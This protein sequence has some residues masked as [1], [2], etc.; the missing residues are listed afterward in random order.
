M[1][2]L[3]NKIL[4]GFGTSV[5]TVLV[6]E[7]IASPRRKK[8]KKAREVEKIE[9]TFKHIDFIKLIKNLIILVYG[10]QNYDS[11]L[12]LSVGELEN[13]VQKSVEKLNN[14]LY[15]ELK[16][17]DYSTR[18]IEIEEF[19][20]NLN[21]KKNSYNQNSIRGL[22]DD[23]CEFFPKMNEIF[24]DK[25][26]ALINYNRTNLPREFLRHDLT[27]NEIFAILDG[28][29]YQEAFDLVINT[30]SEQVNLLLIEIQKSIQ[31]YKSK[32]ENKTKFQ[33]IKE[34]ALNYWNK[35][36]ALIKLKKEQLT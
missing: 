9:E 3:F 31:I 25:F 23:I 35:V 27:S 5:L 21:S 1:N 28:S 24:K 10:H 22:I 33:R 2:N 32:E 20:K 14:T 18:L 4:E 7:L 13:K 30:F 36:I 12:N 34:I 19:L 6:S 8:E 29:L 15:D 11:K 16:I 17:R 26:I